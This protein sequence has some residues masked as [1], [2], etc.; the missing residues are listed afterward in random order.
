MN[1]AS[2]T[3]QSVRARPVVVPLRRPIVSKVGL[4]HDWP[5]ILID[6]YTE[7]G[8]VGHSYLEPYLASAARVVVPLIDELGAAAK[9]RPVA[10]FDA[11]RRS[12]GSLH[13]LGREGVT[14]IAVSALDMAAWDALAQAAGVP[15]A[16]YLGGTVGPVPAYN[17]N[18][19][20]LTAA[21]RLAAEAAAL[22]AEGGF[23]ALK[24]RL[25]R[26]TLDEDL[27]AIAAV[28]EAAGASVKLMC[29]FNQGLTLGDALRRCHALD[30]QGLE[31]F[32]EPIAYDNL[33][34]YVQLARELKTPV[35][36]GENFYGPRLL[37]QAVIAGAGDCVMPDMM[38]IG[39]VSGWLRAA[40]ITGAAGIPM[41]THLYPEISAHLMRVT[42]TA[43]W[44]EW[45][46]WADPILR[47]PFCVEN[48]MLIVPDRP[49]QGIEW[50]EQA[51]AKYAV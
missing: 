45:Q 44:L 18:G 21:D 16:V 29:D 30:D 49:G 13:L 46:D 2:L 3:V 24:L 17:S 40:A 39:G 8:I 9:G 22:V 50:D 33:P 41:S 14:M 1:S 35:Q 12:T 10:P 51:V 28:R 15:L 27:A 47:E 23:K 7:E 4:F 5:L 37:Y 19:L 11:Y 36:L 38:R 26:A 42:E 48:G 43:H 6:L 20:W 32:E 34:G 31:W 25:G